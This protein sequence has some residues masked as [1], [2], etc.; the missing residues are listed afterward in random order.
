[1]DLYEKREFIVSL[2]ESVQ[3]ELIVMAARMPME[4]DGH[5]IR[6]LIAAKFDAERSDMMKMK[7]SKSRYREYVSVAAEI[8]KSTPNK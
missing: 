1:M 4:W 7:K 3:R 2:T 6:E 8:L 5:E